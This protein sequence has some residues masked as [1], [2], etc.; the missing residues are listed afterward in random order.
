MN[1]R[2]PASCGQDGLEALC[3][4]I[5]QAVTE[6]HRG[7]EWPDVSLFAKS[8]DEKGAAAVKALPKH[9]RAFDTIEINLRRLRAGEALGDEWF[10][11]R[12]AV[13]LM[14]KGVTEDDLD[15]YRSALFFKGR[16]VWGEDMARDFELR[17]RRKHDDA[18]EQAGLE[19]Y[20]R[21]LSREAAE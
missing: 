12:R 14:E 13:E 21:T 16:D 5:F 1:K 15:R 20:F 9:E 8:A 18:L 19:R 4:D 3:D 10:F 17:L 7:R 6:A 2:L 11:G